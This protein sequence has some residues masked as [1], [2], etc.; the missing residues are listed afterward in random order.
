[1]THRLVLTALTL[2]VC[3]C[4]GEGVEADPEGALGTEK[5]AL[6]SVA[7]YTQTA[8]GGKQVNTI[9]E[10]AAGR[11]CFISK[12]TGKFYGDDVVD[13]YI[14]NGQWHFGVTSTAPGGMVSANATCVNGTVRYQSIPVTGF[15]GTPGF[16]DLGTGGTCFLNFVAGHF[17][18]SGD[19]VQVG[20]DG[21]SRWNLQATQTSSGSVSAAAVCI[22]NKIPYVL[23]G[24]TTFGTW[25]LGDSS[26]KQILS[27][28][29]HTAACGMFGMKGKFMGSGE[30][31][32]VW[33]DSA[34][35][36]HDIGGNVGGLGAGLGVSGGCV[37]AN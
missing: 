31:V 24:N 14:Y 33:Y 26:P 1:M 27:D 6:S 18:G 16:L 19:R 29:N 9:I 34:A 7:T 30:W 8:S 20:Y 17:G 12:V 5:E 3:A 36:V 22:D 21:V 25:V 11:V 28:P 10:P 4:S 15:P 2:C 37:P 23:K 35:G 32:S 13:V